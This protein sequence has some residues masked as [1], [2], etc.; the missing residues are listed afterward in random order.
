[1]KDYLRV[2]Q[3]A[4]F[5]GISP[6]TVRAWCQRG[7]LGYHVS[8]TGEKVFYPSELEDF[9]REMLGLEPDA[10]KTFFYVR[11]SNGDDV[12]IETQ[13]EKLKAAYGEPD[14]VF[15]D[16]ASGLN[17]KRKGLKALIRDV[18]S[19]EGKVRVFVTNQARLTRFGFTY[20]TELL[21]A[22][23]AEVT[24]LDSPETREPHAVLMEDFMALLAS[25]S[26]KFYRLRGWEQ[27]RKLIDDVSK[28]LDDK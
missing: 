28:K 10:G 9:K 4:K 16:K 3:A 21:T 15:Q 8:I 5:L 7:K 11:S 18:K 24:V 25:F 22:Y 12:L 14:K 23:G 19:E 20:L 17:E 6:S 2:G 27:Q 1:L 26:G 13:L